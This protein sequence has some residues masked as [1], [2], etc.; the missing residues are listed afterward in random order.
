[1]R[2]EDVAEGLS[3]MIPTSVTGN[4][5]YGG[6]RFTSIAYGVI[7]S[8]EITSEDKKCKSFLDDRNRV[9]VK[10]TQPSEMT[11]DGLIAY[12]PKDLELVIG[13][14]QRQAL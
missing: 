6:V 10:I 14:T 4:R 2:L 7:T 9:Y 12:Y 13:N 1:M 11:G 8:R 5:N 3:V